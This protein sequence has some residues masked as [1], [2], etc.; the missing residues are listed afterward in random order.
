MTKV[1]S[2]VAKYCNTN[3]KLPEGDKK[4]L[5]ADV[6]R[7]AKY[8][9]LDL[10][11]EFCGSRGWTRYNEF[12]SN[13]KALAEGCGVKTQKKIE[14]VLN[15]VRPPQIDPLIVNS[16]KRHKIASDPLFGINLLYRFAFEKAFY[17]TASKTNPTIEV[18]ETPEILAGIENLVISGGGA[19]GAVLPGAFREL[20]KQA[21]KFMNQ[22]NEVKGTSVGAITAAMIATGISRETLLEIGGVD[23]EAILGKERIGKS[24][25]N[26][27]YF[28]RQCIRINILFRYAEMDTEKKRAF[29][30][31]NHEMAR[32]IIDQ[33]EEPDIQKVRITFGMLAYLR[34][35]DPEH[36]KEL[37]VTATEKES[38]SL[39]VFN[40]TETPDIDIAKACRAS[41]SIPVVF[42]PV[43][44]K[45]NGESKTFYDGGVI[46]NVP[47]EGYSP[48]KTL[49]FV[50]EKPLAPGDKSIFDPSRPGDPYKASKG[51]RL[52][53]GPILHA[54]TGM[55][56]TPTSDVLKTEELKN[57]KKKYS[58]ISFSPRIAATQFKR[59]SAEAMEFSRL[60][61]MTMRGYLEPQ[62]GSKTKQARVAKLSV[63]TPSAWKKCFSIFKDA[64]SSFFSSLSFLTFDVPLLSLTQ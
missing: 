36:F 7:F 16:N 47:V 34:G 62:N 38:N 35:I 1:S 30:E 42:K 58:K 40:A 57:V 9:T 55:K 45:I 61:K 4:S 15:R 6:L 32:S 14:A 46:S 59:A 24:G 49:V 21:P 12:S 44:M 13:L 39:R 3:F 50:F 56:L 63:S 64:M 26:L 52:L 8:H 18:K 28:I 54:V 22:I 10:R 60:G 33:L 43:H 29:E 41:A 48:E 27:V 51:T 2:F 20:F 53:R 17:P 19:K 23:I 11:K 5:A 31:R 37:R 25:E